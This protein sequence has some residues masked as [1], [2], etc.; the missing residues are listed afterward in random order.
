MRKT[1]FVKLQQEIIAVQYI[2]YTISETYFY[3]LTSHV[4]K[5][6]KFDIWLFP[7]VYFIIHP[8]RV[9]PWVPLNEFKT[10]K[11]TYYFVMESSIIKIWKVEN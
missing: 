11:N 1:I 3:F 9:I 10:L 7:P 8:L 2:I 5:V 4:Y 6:W